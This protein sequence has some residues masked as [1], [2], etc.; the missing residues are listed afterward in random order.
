MAGKHTGALTSCP[1][2]PEM[3]P[4]ISK[5]DITGLAGSVGAL[6]SHG[7]ARLFLASWESG[8]RSRT[9]ECDE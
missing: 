4:K 8:R 1:V 7:Q 9:W 6:A 3:S 2:S 5:S